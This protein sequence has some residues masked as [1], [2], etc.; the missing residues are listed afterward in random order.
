MDTEITSKENLL[1]KELKKAS[2]GKN[3]DYLFIEGKKL[4]LEAVNSSIQIKKVFTCK[5]NKDFTSKFLLHKNDSELILC[6]DSLLASAFTTENKPTSSDDL[7]IA[8]AK[9]SDWQLIDLFSSN[10]NLVFL[11]RI[12]D[13]GNLGAVIRSSLAFGAGGIVLTKG[14]VDPFNTKVIRASAGG[15]FK[16][17]VIYV[18]E[19][20]IIKKLAKEKKYLIVAASNKNPSKSLNKMDLNERNVFLFGNEGSGLSKGLLYMADETINIP[21]VKEVESLNL[22]IAVSIVLWEQYKN[23]NNE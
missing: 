17:P 21:H 3:S 19:A 6:K 14:S 18:Q 23:K 13:P 12:Q 10:K 11:E 7:I 5:K 8:L 2:L 1:Y 20:K 9:K 16:L 15:V 22:G 4:F